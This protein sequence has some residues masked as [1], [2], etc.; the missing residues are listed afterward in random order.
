MNMWIKVS[1]RRIYYRFVVFLFF[2][3][4]SF[5]EIVLLLF[6]INVVFLGILEKIVFFYLMYKILKLCKG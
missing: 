4:R 5:I 2:V 3:I 1:L 6:I